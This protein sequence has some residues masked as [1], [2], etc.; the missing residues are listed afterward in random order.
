LILRGH[1]TADGA[2]A[3][4]LAEHRPVVDRLE[5]ERL[6]FGGE[7]RFDIGERGARAGRNHELLRLVERDAREPGQ[8]EGRA[9]L[10]R[11]PDRALRS[12]ADDV[13]RLA[14]AERPFHG[15]FD[16]ADIAG[17]EGPFH[18]CRHRHLKT[19]N[20]RKRQAPA[21]DMHAP[22]LRAGME[23]RKHLSRIKEALVVEGAFDPLLLIEIDLREHHRHQVALLD[24][25]AVLAGQ[26]PANLDA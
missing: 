5:G 11:T 8:V 4:G 17:L 15:G 21:A 13:E 1:R 22:E 23:L 9:V 24:P 25:D 19:W 12:L 26:H 16:I 2:A 6:A 7:R 18:Q 10:R 3:L 14:A 20:I